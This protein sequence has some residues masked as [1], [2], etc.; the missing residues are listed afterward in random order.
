MF[1]R[2]WL[3]HLGSIGN[4]V[5]MSKLIPGKLYRTCR[6]NTLWANTINHCPENVMIADVSKNSI[7]MFVEMTEDNNFNNWFHVV[8]S[9]GNGW[10]VET[11]FT[12]LIPV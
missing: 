11:S 6:V 10:F 2:R 8:C 12:P 9:K 4:K 5:C 1:Y 3:S 7:V